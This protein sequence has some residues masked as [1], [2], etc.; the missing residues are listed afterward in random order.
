MSSHIDGDDVLFL[1]NNVNN[2]ADNKDDRE[3]VD[4]GGVVFVMEIGGDGDERE[5]RKDAVAI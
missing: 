2:D 1:E 4:D 3:R 5:L